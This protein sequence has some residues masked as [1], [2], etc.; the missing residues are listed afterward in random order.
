MAINKIGCLPY[1]SSNVAGD[2]KPTNT[3]R[4]NARRKR[5]KHVTETQRRDSS[6]VLVISFWPCL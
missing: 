5:I 2:T 6:A 1:R 4:T 3:R